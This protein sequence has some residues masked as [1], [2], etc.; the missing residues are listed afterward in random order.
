MR[1]FKV[2]RLSVFLYKDIQWNIIKP[3]WA[4]IPYCYIV[5]VG[6][7]TLEFII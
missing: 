4:V 1:L 7:L 5:N 3:C 6:F 2:G